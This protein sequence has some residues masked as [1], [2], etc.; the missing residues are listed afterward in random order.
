M[1]PRKSF[2]RI[3]RLELVSEK[4][5][6]SLL[7]G[8][9]RSVFRGPGI[10]FDE[11]RE[12]VQGDDARLIDWNVSS[13]LG[14]AYTKT[15]REEREMTL[16]LLVDVS[17]SVVISPG[18]GMRKELENFLVAMLALAA[19]RNNDKVGAAF[20]AERI[21]KWV[22]PRKGKHHALRLLQDI[23]TFTPKTRGSNLAAALRTVGETLT[24]RGICVII[25]DFKTR[26][27]LREMSL[28]A[29]RHDVIA[30]RVSEP[31]D[32]E[33]PVSGGT[34]LQDPETGRTILAT[35]QNPS[36]RKQYREFWNRERQ[37][38][39]RDCRR[40]RVSP[41]EISTTD[42]PATKLIQFFKRRK[43]R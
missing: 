41:L 25:S 12:Y 30:V 24:R 26:G 14:S 22:P 3:R 11:V 37:Q 17:G 32:Y 10:E 43:R 7:A 9:Y 4:L 5:V 40:L 20:F 39:L 29:R 13:R 16:F 33:Y 21:E 27:Y 31:T 28:L 34:F 2:S 6:Q 42:D 15:F 23:T 8:N 36:F 35:G 18:E 38:W 19:L 1:R